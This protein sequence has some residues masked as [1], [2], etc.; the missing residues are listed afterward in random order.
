MKKNVQILMVA[1]SAMVLFGAC[2][3]STQKVNDAR[4]VAAA[5]SSLGKFDNCKHSTIAKKTRTAGTQFYS[6]NAW[7]GTG[8]IFSHCTSNGKGTPPQ[9]N[10]QIGSFGD[11]YI[12]DGSNQ[13]PLV[14]K[15]IATEFQS[16]TIYALVLASSNRYE[17]WQFAASDPNSATYLSTITFNGNGVSYP[18]NELVDIETDYNNSTLN[19]TGP[20]TPGSHTQYRLL[21]LDVSTNEIVSLDINT[22]IIFDK[23]QFVTNGVATPSSI[24]LNGTNH[25]AVTNEKEMIGEPVSLCWMDCGGY[26][27]NPYFCWNGH[28]HPI[29]LSHNQDLLYMNKFTGNDWSQATPGFNQGWSASVSDLDDPNK[30]LF[31]PTAPDDFACLSEMD[32]VTG[33]HTANFFI[34]NENGEF[35]E[36]LNSIMGPF[37][38]S[39]TFNP[40]TVLTSQPIIDFAPFY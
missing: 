28:G 35:D 19:N 32:A 23:T 40:Q 12:R 33:F 31:S 15:G 37:N 13:Q 21:A 26:F 36:D 24:L 14:V 18:N 8:N 9:I 30:I 20:C 4:N 29:V 16:T 34:A 38:S 25:S 5:E 7:D 17:I 1:L 6:V 10:G 22:G 3:K 39:N 2:A 11:A 27:S